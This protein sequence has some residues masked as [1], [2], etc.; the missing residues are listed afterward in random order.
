MKMN[1]PDKDWPEEGR[2]EAS[3]LEKRAADVGS[4]EKNPLESDSAEMNAPAHSS[5]EMNTPAHRSPDQGASEKCAQH[6]YVKEKHTLPRGSQENTPL[7]GP[8]ESAPPIGSQE[9]TLPLGPQEKE[10]VDH[11]GSPGA[12]VP[13]DWLPAELRALPPLSPS[14]ELTQRV[15]RAALAELEGPHGMS[16]SAALARGWRAYLEWALYRAALPGALAGATF[17]YLSWAVTAAS[18]LY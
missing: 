13:K 10:P 6:K 4:P 14:P 17:I 8:Q 12:F 5:A 1:P 3:A 15:A 2:P 18:H 9:N 7:L 11:Q 16:G